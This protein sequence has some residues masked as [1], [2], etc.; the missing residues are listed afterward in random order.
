MKFSGTVDNERKKQRLHFGDV[1]IHHLD[2]G[3]FRDRAIVSICIWAPRP[4]SFDQTITILSLYPQVRILPGCLSWQQHH[5]QNQENPRT[6]FPRNQL[7]FKGKLHHHRTKI[8]KRF[9]L[10][11][12][13]L[14]TVFYALRST[15]LTPLHQHQVSPPRR[16]TGADS[17]V[18]R[19]HTS[20]AVRSSLRISNTSI[21]PNPT[22]AF[23]R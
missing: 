6:F 2:P 3:V 11:P 4:W 13:C 12:M 10:A 20:T 5:S 17:S 14:Q 21:T 19:L 9:L 23:I 16:S 1:L 8:L 22:D 18:E 7:S 15:L